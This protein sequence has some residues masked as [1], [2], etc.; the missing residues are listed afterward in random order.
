MSY[1]E[2]YYKSGDVFEIKWRFC[3]RFIPDIYFLG[4]TIKREGKEEPEVL[5]RGADLV[6]FKVIG[7]K[8]FD[9]GGYIDVDFQL[10]P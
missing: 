9:R 2:T 5:F 10:E 8:G 4:L 3:C 7:E 6:V 1:S